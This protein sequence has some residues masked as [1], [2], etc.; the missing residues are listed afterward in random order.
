MRGCE[1]V[2][3]GGGG[4]HR[5]TGRTEAL[6]V[7]QLKPSRFCKP[8]FSG[9]REAGS[10]QGLELPPNPRVVAAVAG[11]RAGESR[12][13]SAVIGGRTRPGQSAP[14][15]DHTWPSGP[16]QVYGITNPVSDP[17]RTQQVSI[18]GICQPNK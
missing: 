11:L 18:L 5:S 14:H 10:N 4:S 13:V 9:P 3:V 6:D 12:L 15:I 8:F 17:L 7:C 1:G 2:C 16:H